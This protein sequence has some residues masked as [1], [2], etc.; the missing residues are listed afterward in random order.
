MT[1]QDALLKM[2]R[3]RRRPVAV[4]VVDGDS[5][6]DRTR[7]GDWQSEP[8]P[9]AQKAFGH[10]R[11]LANDLPEALDFRCLVGLHVV[12]QADRGDARAMRL[13]S[14]VKAAEP[15]FLIAVVGDEVLTFPEV[16]THG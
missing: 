16:P 13:F 7:A 10:I 14:A 15:A 11:V 2:R 8:N 4:F 6:Y 1:G 12:L 3:T 5:E 9:F